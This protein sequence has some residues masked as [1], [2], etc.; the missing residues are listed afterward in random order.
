MLSTEVRDG[1]NYMIKDTDNAELP[2]PNECALIL[3]CTPGNI[4]DV[5]EDMTVRQRH[6]ESSVIPL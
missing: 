4:K 2:G 1:M 6:S 5:M 3:Y